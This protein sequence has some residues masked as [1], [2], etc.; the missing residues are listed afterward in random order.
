MNASHTSTL[1]MPSEIFAKYLQLSIY[2]IYIIN[3]MYNYNFI[4]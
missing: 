4:V 1:A 3:F 2:L